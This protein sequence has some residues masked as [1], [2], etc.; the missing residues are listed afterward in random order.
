M[1]NSKI[2]D[3]SRVVGRITQGLSLK[4]EQNLVGLVLSLNLSLVSKVKQGKGGSS[5]DQEGDVEPA[6][7]EVEL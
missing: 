4:T 1:K 6:V 7:V 5:R 2:V 3:H